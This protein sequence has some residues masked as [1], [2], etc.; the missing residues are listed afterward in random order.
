[1]HAWSYSNDYSP[2]PRTKMQHE[3]LTKR[4]SGLNVEV[5]LGFTAEQVAKEVERCLNCDIETHF[6]ASKCIECDACVDVCP[7]NCLTIAYDTADDFDLVAQ[8]SAP[9]E[10]ADQAL[11]TSA[12]LPQTKRIMV[13]DEDVCLH[14]GLCA[15]RCPTAAWDMA[16]FDLLVPYAGRGVQHA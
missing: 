9:R 2:V 11:Y 10:H 13:K 15:E 5:E 16:K 14:C 3:E 4:F 8:L 7:V 1:M 6:T 12:Q